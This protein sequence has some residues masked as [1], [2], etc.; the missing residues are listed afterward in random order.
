MIFPAAVTATW[1]NDEGRRAIRNSKSYTRCRGYCLMIIDTCYEDPVDE[2]IDSAEQGL[3]AIVQML[4][5]CLQLPFT[6]ND[7][8]AYAE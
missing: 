2:N 4:L 3:K 7:D 5:H 1:I 6:R 8:T